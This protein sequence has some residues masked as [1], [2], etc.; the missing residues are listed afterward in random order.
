MNHNHGQTHWRSLDP[1]RQPQNLDGIVA[2][3]G[4]QVPPG[5][6]RDLRRTVA[7][8]LQHQYDANP[9]ER[10]KEMAE[11]FNLAYPNGHPPEVVGVAYDED[12]YHATYGSSLPKIPHAP[13]EAI[14]VNRLQ[15]FGQPPSMTANLPLP[16]N[17]TGGCCEYVMLK[18]HLKDNLGHLRTIHS[19]SV[20][21]KVRAEFKPLAFCDNCKLLATRAA[22]KYYGLRIVDDATGDVYQS[23]K[24]AA[25]YQALEMQRAQAHFASP[26]ASA[27]P[28]PVA[29]HRAQMLP[30]GWAMPNPHNDTRA[31][32]LSR[33][34]W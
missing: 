28:R 27:A 18:P 19:V 10:V 13:R 25:A 9:W 21:A 2:Q 4:H 26:A 22:E 16:R 1:R 12:S 23:T 3:W 14:R 15:A 5:P 7:Y 8:G 20:R 32:L 17:P 34:P 11:G 33:R 24:T 6:D 30:H 29:G 31:D